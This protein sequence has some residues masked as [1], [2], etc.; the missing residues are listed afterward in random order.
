MKEHTFVIFRQIRK[1]CAMNDDPV[2]EYVHGS[3]ADAQK[4]CNKLNADSTEYYY[5]MDLDDLK[6]H[7]FQV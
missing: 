1:E 2:I 6:A 5:Y 4:V 7:G 3:N